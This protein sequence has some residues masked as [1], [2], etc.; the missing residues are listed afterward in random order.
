MSMYQLMGDNPSMMYLKATEDLVEKGDQ[1]SPR[2]KLISELRPAC[3][4]FENPYNRVTFLEGRRINPFFQIAESLWILSGRSDVEFLVKFNENMK[5][6]SDDG[7]WFNAAYGERMRMWNKNALHNVIINPVD[8]LV[9]VY[10]KLLHDKDTRQ[11]VIVISNPMFDNSNYTIDEKGKDIACNLVITF[12]IRHNKLNMTVFN[13]SNDLHWGVFGANLCQ[14]S[15]I[16]ECLLSWLKASKYPE[17]E[18]GTYNQITD[19]LHIYLDDYGFKITNEVLGSYKG[20]TMQQITDATTG[21]EFPNEPRMSL[22]IDQFDVFLGYFWNQ[23]NPYLMD[24]EYLTIGRQRDALFGKEGTMEDWHKQGIIDDY[25]YFG[26]QSMVAYRLVKL[27]GIVDAL[28]Y[29]T[30]MVNCQWKV[31]MLYFLKSFIRKLSTGEDGDTR[32]QRAAQYYIDNVKSLLNDLAQ[33]SVLLS[34]EHYLKLWDK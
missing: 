32:Y 3:L 28:E 2:G 22:D 29:M 31:S 20:K 9:D 17:L 24:D 19:S 6:F 25:W 1:V 13:R 7:K 11:A 15:T 10:R 4:E 34:L 27:G 23:L 5:Q 14:F 21:Y 33:P 16:Q 12:K 18:M 26:I 30:N 8:Q